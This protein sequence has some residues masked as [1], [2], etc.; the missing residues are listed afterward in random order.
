MTEILNDI[1]SA[2]IIQGLEANWCDCIRTFGLAP[3]VELHDEPEILWMITGIPSG[4][5]NGVQQARLSPDK[6]EAAFA[7]VETRHKERQVPGGWL[8]GPGTRP[9]SL[10][11]SLETHGL[12]KVAS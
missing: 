12:K 1:S 6:V 8:I 7:Q 5:F 11:Q 2:A 10:S 9:D 4:E 3:Q